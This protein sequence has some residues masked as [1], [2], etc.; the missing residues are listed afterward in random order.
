MLISFLKQQHFVTI[1]T[2]NKKK[3]IQLKLKQTLIMKTIIKPLC[4]LVFALIIFNCDNDDDATTPNVDVCNFQ[5]LTFLDDSSNTQTLIP[6]SDLTANYIT[7]GSNG[8]EIEVYLTSDPGYF[9]FTTIAVNENDSGTSF[10]NFNGNSYSSVVTT[11]Q[12]G[13]TGST[14]AAIGDEFRYDIVGNGVEIELCVIVDQITL[15]Y[16]DADGDGC[17]S[18]TISYTFGVLNNIDLD[19]TDPNICL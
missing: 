15:G 2:N 18:Q 4:L 16:I 6:E 7:G 13:V 17:G 19:D 5:G 9:N 3:Q 8:P 11:C 10:I 14:G 1:I 12:R